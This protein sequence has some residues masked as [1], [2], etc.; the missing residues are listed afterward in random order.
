M[1][2]FKTVTRVVSHSRK[3]ERIYKTI[4]IDLAH[5]V[6]AYTDISTDKSIDA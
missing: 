4:C 6:A 1:V 2:F 3:D 5:D